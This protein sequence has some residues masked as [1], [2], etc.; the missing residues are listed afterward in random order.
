MAIQCSKVDYMWEGSDIYD[1]HPQILVVS[2]GLK[3]Q[4]ITELFKIQFLQVSKY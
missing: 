1:F 4:S 2:T 3:K